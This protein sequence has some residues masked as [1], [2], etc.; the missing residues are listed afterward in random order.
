MCDNPTPLVSREFKSFLDKWGISY[1]TSS[2]HYPQSN[3]QAESAVK[4]IKRLMEASDDQYLALLAYSNTPI[5]G[6]KVSPAQLCIGRNLRF[7]VPMPPQK[8]VPEIPP[9]T[10]IRDKD[11]VKSAAQKAHY[12]FRNKT[13]IHPRYWWSCVDQK[14]PTQRQG[15]VQ[16]LRAQEGNSITQRTIFNESFVK[17]TWTMLSIANVRYYNERLLQWRTFAIFNETLL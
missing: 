7:T 10:E 15:G 5:L 11:Q 2:P 9:T 17:I 4:V 13:R 3:D 12:D 16:V 1:I 6:L 8:F 14:Y